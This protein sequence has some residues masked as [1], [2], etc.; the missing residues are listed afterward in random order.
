MSRV[1]GFCTWVL[2]HSSL[3]AKQGPS[4]YWQVTSSL[5]DMQK[6][7]KN[8][9]SG[10][11]MKQKNLCN[12]VLQSQRTEAEQMMEHR[13][14]VKSVSGYILMSCIVFLYSVQRKI[15]GKR[16]QDCWKLVAFVFLAQMYM[17]SLFWGQWCNTGKS[18]AYGLAVCFNSQQV[19]AV[20]A[21]ST[22]SYTTFNPA[23]L[24]PTWY[25]KVL[26]LGPCCSERLWR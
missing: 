2:L 3:L 22:T 9:K 21:S 5:C 8:G 10:K 24:W 4:K 17:C 15:I 7:G 1:K 14:Q 25:V 19:Q 6:R 26:I 16:L 11:Y 18:G 13:R 20:T 12:D 23:K